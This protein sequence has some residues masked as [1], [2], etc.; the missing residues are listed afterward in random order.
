MARKWGQENEEA[1]TSSCPYFLANDLTT[2]S[3]I[4]RR[5][6]VFSLK[7]N[8]FL[9]GSA[10]TLLMFSWMPTVAMADEGDQVEGE[11]GMRV[12]DY[13]DL[14]HKRLGFSG[15]VLA[16]RDG[17]VVATIPRGT[18][19]QPGTK[20]LTGSTLFEIASSTKMFTAIAV[21][22]L[23]EAKKLSLDDSI[24]DHLPNVPDNCRKITIR[25][26]LS[27]TS[28]IPGTN[29][30][31][32]GDDIEKVLPTFLSGGPQHPP[33]THYEYW[34]Q[35]YSLL[36]EIIA[37]AS[38]QTYSQCLR[39]NI[40]SRCGMTLS[41]FTGDDV[42]DGASVAMGKSSRGASRSALEHPYGS[43]GFQ[44]RGMGGL[45]TNVQELWQWD[46][47]MHNN[48]L[49]NEQLLKE[50][51]T[52]G[53]NKHGL[54]G[55]GLGCLIAKDPSG[56]ASHQHSGGVRGFLADVRRY[57][58][59]DGAIFILSNS[60]ESL[61]FELIQSGVEQ[62]LFGNKPGTSIPDQPNI[63][64]VKRTAGQYLDANGRKLVIEEATGL[65]SIKIY[66][67]G[68]VTAG[69]VG[70]SEAGTPSLYM[71]TSNNGTLGF[72]KDS[73]LEF[74][75]SNGQATSVSLLGLVPK[76]TF[77]REK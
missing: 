30:I 3:P 65:P 34:N 17:K 28:G 24:A 67:G 50:M 76:L 22:Q 18:T 10:F 54:S 41:R 77:K 33:G 26:L 51:T 12:R 66:W 25:H 29:T 13:V 4:E 75:P 71:L 36:S 14:I 32:A 1:T 27:H 8:R 53:P 5:Q 62:I 11:V 47:A 56:K 57:P 7:I 9:L 74:L 52:A 69:I 64:L 20:P 58:S 39:D 68:P 42:P 45:V 23:A 31:G 63:E 59:I 60:D 61:P 46:R 16:A 21:L 48:Q 55:H 43:Y 15:V 6:Q 73:E 35:G 37:R 19:V 38:G 49:I 40:F 2:F 70:L 72:T 44:Y